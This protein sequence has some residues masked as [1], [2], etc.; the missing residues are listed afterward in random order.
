MTVH[1]KAPVTRNVHRR[2]RL[3]DRVHAEMREDTAVRAFLG[4]KAPRPALS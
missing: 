2:R 3:A 4:L 1:E